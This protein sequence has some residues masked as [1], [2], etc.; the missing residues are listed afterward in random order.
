[1]LKPKVILK[2]ANP[3]WHGHRGSSPVPSSA[4]PPRS[5]G[6]LVEVCDAQ[7]RSLGHGFINP[8][9]Q[10][11]CA[12]SPALASRSAAVSR[13]LGSAAADFH[14][15]SAC[16]RALGAHRPADPSAAALRQRFGLPCARYH[17]PIGKLGKATGRRSVHRHLR[18]RRGGAVYG[19][20]HE[21]QRG[22][23]LAGPKD[24]ASPPAAIVETAASSFA[25]MRAEAPPH[26]TSTAIGADARR[27]RLQRNGITLT[28][29]LKAG[30]KT[31]M[32]LDQRD[33]RQ[34]LGRYA[35][36]AQVLDVYS[37][38]GG[39]APGAASRRARA[40][41]VTSRRGRWPCQSHAEPVRAWAP[42]HRGVRCL[43]PGSGTAATI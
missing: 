11:W 18:R 2:R 28:V 15:G 30:Q 34:L 4:P 24:P 27:R 39:F 43:P 25:Q 20:W 6:D 26:G 29:D 3:V 22:S 10:M 37:Y 33:N 17:R 41:C 16:R 7:E 23:G 13:A 42:A 31:G 8:R 19:P 9:S 21:A 36:G 5:S 12:C 35:A 38:A 14:H 1:M 32:F 40:T